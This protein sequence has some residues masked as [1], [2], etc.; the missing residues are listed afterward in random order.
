MKF[1]KRTVP[2]EDTNWVLIEIS[3]Q[4]ITSNRKSSKTLDRHSQRNSKFNDIG[5]QLLLWIRKSTS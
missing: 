2:F 1:D 3:T 4:N 5:L